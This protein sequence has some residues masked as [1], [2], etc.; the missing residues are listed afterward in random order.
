MMQVPPAHSLLLDHD[1][2][3]WLTAVAV[4]LDVAALAS[5]WIGRHHS[6]RAK[7]VWTGIAL[8]VPVLGALG[9]FFLGHERP[10]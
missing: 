6:V 1:W 9:W 10:R 2:L 5:I 8:V 3:L 7:T 4:I